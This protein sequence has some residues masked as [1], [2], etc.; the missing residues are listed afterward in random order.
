MRMVFFRLAAVMFSVGFFCLNLPAKEEDKADD[1]KSALKE[2]E[3]GFDYVESVFWT[4]I[5]LGAKDSFYLETDRKI[6]E[7]KNL[8]RK[9]VQMTIKEKDAEYDVTTPMLGISSIWSNSR[10]KGARIPSGIICTSR[11]NYMSSPGMKGER[12]FRAEGRNM[13]VENRKKEFKDKEYLEWVAGATKKCID[14]YSSGGGSSSY[15]ERRGGYVLK[16]TSGMSAFL[17]KYFMSVRDIRKRIINIEKL[18]AKLEKEAEA[19]N[20]ASVHSSAYSDNA[21]AI[22]AV[23]TMIL[24]DVFMLWS[25]R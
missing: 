18:S 24:S 9:L 2:F 12:V 14:I 20:N 11:E 22:T 19:P 6:T 8:S 21:A 16:S 1:I 3:S 5:V 25:S 15:D 4:A 10:W 17:T 23:K 7:L 13:V